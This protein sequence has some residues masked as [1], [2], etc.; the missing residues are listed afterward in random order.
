MRQG[1][2]DFMYE[3]G[4]I[5]LGVVASLALAVTMASAGAK[6]D[7]VSGPVAALSRYL[8]AYA[9]QLTSVVASETYKQT[10]VHWPQTVSA[11]DGDGRSGIQMPRPAAGS[12][13]EKRSRTLTASLVY[14]RPPGSTRWHG[15]RDLKSVDGFLLPPLPIQSLLAE[16]GEWALREAERYA[17]TSHYYDVGDV[18]RALNTPTVALD[19]LSPRHNA[20]WVARLR[21]QERLDGRTLQRLEF[22]ERQT[23]SLLSAVVGPDQ[24][25][26]VT[27]LVE[28]QTG[29]MLQTRLE[30]A[31]TKRTRLRTRVT[32]TY[33]FDPILGLNVPD[34]MDETYQSDD[35]E[36]SMTMTG[37]ATYASYRRL[38]AGR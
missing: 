38:N 1:A 5:T 33:R 21:G 16:G 24:L 19:L 34:R 7:D 4:A 20:R 14:L 6:A 25:A 36:A 17:N 29:T 26:K 27:A 9:T 11:P 31:S 23:P 30:I 18:P 12:V 8:D 15:F 32:V 22:T 10:F 35:P 13:V 28:A 2:A 37:T 3:T